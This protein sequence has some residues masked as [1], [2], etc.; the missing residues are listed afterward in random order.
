MVRLVEYHVVDHCNLNCRGCAHFAPVGGERFASVDEF[1]RSLTSL[2]R[3]QTVTSVRL[4][5]GEPLL[6]PKLFE[7]THAARV[8]LGNNA[9]V[10]VMTNGILLDKLMANI[11]HNLTKDRV[12][13]EVTRYPLPDARYDEAIRLIRAFGVIVN[14]VNDDTKT[15]RHHRLDV[16]GGHLVD[17]NCVMTAGE[18]SLQLKNN[19]LFRCPI[20]AYVHRLNSASGSNFVV[21]EDDVLSLYAA[22]PA[23]VERFQA[24]RNKFCE[25]C[26]PCTYGHPFGLSKR[27][28]SEWTVSDE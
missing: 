10:R 28:L 20:T 19:F 6:H 4:M 2:A 5:G 18:G 15:L 11:V 26:A 12:T 25:N 17:D 27:R 23:D 3:I 8:I 22:T 21:P 24:T 1:T 13:L 7:F 16:N 9:D 14:V